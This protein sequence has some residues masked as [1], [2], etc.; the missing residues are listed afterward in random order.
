MVLYTFN[1]IYSETDQEVHDD[2]GHDEE[3]GT[4][5]DV[6]EPVMHLVLSME[7]VI[8]IKLTD[9][10]DRRANDGVVGCRV[11]GLKSKILHR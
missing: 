11:R 8:V 5:E 7:D 4:E 1:I 6:G 9:H 2:D 3:E 10:H